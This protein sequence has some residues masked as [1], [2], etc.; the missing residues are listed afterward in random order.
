MTMKDLIIGVL[1]TLGVSVG[2]AGAG[3]GSDKQD[4]GN[5]PIKEVKIPNPD[6]PEPPEPT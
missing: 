5:K 3:T 4:N 6:V 2:V 1:V